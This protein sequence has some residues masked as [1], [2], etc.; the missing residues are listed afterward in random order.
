ML[1]ILSAQWPE[2]RI[3]SAFGRVPLPFLPLGATSCLAVQR[4]MAPGESCVLT[5]PQAFLEAAE[6]RLALDTADICLLPQPDGLSRAAMLAD[7]LRRI[8]PHGP[9]RVLFGDTLLPTPTT[10]S[11]DFVALTDAPTPGPALVFDPAAPPGGRFAEAEGPHRLSVCGGFGAAD[12]A[13]LAGAMRDGN[14]RDGLNAYD[15][16]RPLEPWVTSGGATLGTLETYLEAKSRSMYSR[17]FNAVTRHGDR[18]VKRSRN[19]A[20]IAAEA[21]WYETLPAQLQDTIPAYL[22][23]T[24]TG[25]RPEYALAFLGL[26]TLGELSVFGAAPG[27]TWQTIVSGC[28]ALLERYQSI[29]PQPGDVAASPAF[30]SAFHAAMHI[31]KSRARIAAYLRSDES[32]GSSSITLNGRRHPPVGEVVE[33]MIEAIRPT[34]ADDV[35][36]WH[37]DFHYGNLLFDASSDRVFSI[38]PRGQL[39]GGGMTSFGDFRYDVAK[40]AHSVLGRYDRILMGAA[41]LTIDEASSWRFTT[42]ELPEDAAVEARFLDACR[43]RFGVESAELLAL[44]ALLFFSMLPLHG[45]RPDL[46]RMFLAAGLQLAG[47]ARTER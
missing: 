29:R 6:A 16:R 40:L 22:G 9:V 38:D 12:G 18:I 34:R 13:L 37:G 5:I 7:A 43:S 26:P 31:G 32:G 4:R 23:R 42:R 19:D 44:T 11:A 10:R 35:R 20:K 41:R 21:R 28:C 17:A 30:A 15:R 24:G 1:I 36:F 25:G 14:L 46:Q 27:S 8:A 45:E 33:E 3:E 39:E 47:R 2:A